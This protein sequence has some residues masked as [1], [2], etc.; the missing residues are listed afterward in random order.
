M[1]FSGRRI[2]DAVDD[3]DEWYMVD[4]S[5]MDGPPAMFDSVQSLQNSVARVVLK[6]SP[7]PYSGELLLKLHWLPIQSRIEF[8]IARITYIAL[9][10][11]QPTYLGTLL[12]YHTPQRTLRSSNQYFLQQPPV[13][14]EFAKRPF[15]YLA[16][17]MW[18]NIAL[19]IR[20]S[21]TLPTFKRRRT[22]LNSFR[23]SLPPSST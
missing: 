6:N 7:I 20:L 13:S 18:N 11:A 3:C 23:I 14:A 1:S 2:P 10:T 19:Y 9:T 12:N 4:W 16:A 8:K 5:L 22:Y 15:S 21:H 17:K